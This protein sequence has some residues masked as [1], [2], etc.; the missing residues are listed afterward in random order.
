MPMGGRDR[1]G[2]RGLAV[3]KARMG[4]RRSAR[5]QCGKQVALLLGQVKCQ[6]GCSEAASASLGLG[7]GSE[8]EGN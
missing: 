1:A 2:T 8:A 3:A 5:Q 4:R 6:H 7:G